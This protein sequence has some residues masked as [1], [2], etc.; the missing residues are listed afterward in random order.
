MRKLQLACMFAGDSSVCLV[1]EC[2][3]GL[4]PLSRRVI[5]EILLEQRSR[6]II[7]LTT[8]FLDEVEVLA[9]HVVILSKGQVK[10]YGPTTVLKQLHGGGYEV[11]IPHSNVP[12]HQSYPHIVH[13][14]QLIY[15]TPNST[16]AAHLATSLAAAGVSDVSITG[17]QVEDVFLQVAG[18]PVQLESTDPSSSDPNFHLTPGKLATFWS[19]AKTIF[20]KR[21][22][23]LRRYWWPYIYVLILPMAVTPS[24]SGIL[25]GYTASLCIDIQPTLY[26]GHEFYVSY[27]GSQ[28]I[29][30]AVKTSPGLLLGGP[31]SVNES[32]YNFMSK[33][34]SVTR[35]FDLSQYSE[36]VRPVATLDEFMKYLNENKTRV[37]PGGIFMENSTSNPVIAI[38][39][40]YGVEEGMSLIN[41]Y[42]QIRSGSKITAS[43]GTMG[44]MPAR[45][46]NSGIFYA[47]FFCL[48]QAVYPAAFALYPSIE[49]RRKV[50]AVGYA[51]GVRRTPLW[52]AYAFF[53]FLFVSVISLAITSHLGS[54]VPLWNGGAW[55]MLPILA[56]YGLAALLFSYIM[57]I[58]CR[59]G[60]GAFLATS[61]LNTLMLTIVVV[62]FVGPNA[63]VD[64]AKVDGLMTA[65]TFGLNI[66]FPIGNVFRSVAFGLNAMDIGCRDGAI[67]PASSIHAYG[68]PALYLIIQ[69]ATLLGILVWL[70]RD[71]S[72]RSVEA[73]NHSPLT[74]DSEKLPGLPSDE[75]K[76][77][78]ARVEKA[79]DDP[80]R[81]LHLTKAFGRNIAVNDTSIGIGKGEVLA[82]IGPN[83]AGKSTLVD[84]I[85]GGLTSDYGNGYLRRKRKKCFCTEASRRLYSVRCPGLF[86][87][88]KALGLLRK[89][90]GCRECAA[91]R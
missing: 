69:V 66:F 29:D 42:S 46:A 90:Q 52:V 65:T 76:V 43:Y 15:K 31:S 79:T 5:W 4:D 62:A 87:Y 16:S 80:L 34:G 61:L 40:E 27:G 24:F 47:V 73:V 60:P 86:E 77:E 84:L 13:Q 72:L 7:I 50:R 54:K 63:F 51:N 20:W 74:A 14:D 45:S 81:A 83:G 30:G 38:L 82:L 33:N 59:T 67:V 91:E 56:L 26:S 39:T 37:L 28:V 44:V 35:Y 8:H 10:C 22:M 48:M 11:S 68:G 53:D 57:S 19:Q 88:R 6:R 1:D 21:I 55:L 85:R 32:L 64:I 41:L 75:V 78:A 25:K 17:P 49:K 71:H 89:D 3:S 70:E 9:D 23:V 12:I 18:Y 36:W 58:L 2:T